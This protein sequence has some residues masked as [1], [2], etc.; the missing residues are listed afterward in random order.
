MVVPFKQT[1]NHCQVF[2][3]NSDIRIKKIEFFPKRPSIIIG[4]E[5][6]EF[7]LG[8]PESTTALKNADVS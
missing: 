7:Q 6:D 1:F 5:A 3:W 2:F 8:I 4:D